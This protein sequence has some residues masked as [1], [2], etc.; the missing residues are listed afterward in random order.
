MP[1]AGSFSPGSIASEQSLP[2][3][4]LSWHPSLAYIYTVP[5]VSLQTDLVQA[6]PTSEDEPRGGQRQI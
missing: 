6:L 4:L 2:R 3:P 5:T 1:K